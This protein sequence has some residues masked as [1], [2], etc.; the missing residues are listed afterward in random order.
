MNRPADGSTGPSS[1]DPEGQLPPRPLAAFDLDGT[2]TRRDTLRPFLLRAIGRDR[3]YRAL[4]ACSLPLARAAALGGPH[5]DI[6]KVAVLQKTLGGLPLASLAELA[7]PFADHVVAHGLRADV[8]ARV[9]WHREQGHELVLVSASPEL[10]ET[11]IGRR[12]GFD[13]VLATR[14]EVDADGRLTGNLL[15]TNCRGPEK[16]LRLRE[17]RGESISVAYAYGD[18]AGDRE[19]L[20]LSSIGVKV[21]RRGLPPA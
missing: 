21:R 16:V 2:L 14:L 4:F 18:S 7:D 19:M 17:W 13:A 8:R 1:T 6:A 11:P 12:L 9:D 5:R 3:T 10:D 20:A 15:G